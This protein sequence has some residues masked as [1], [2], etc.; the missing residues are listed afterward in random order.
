MNSTLQLLAYSEITLSHPHVLCP[1][2]TESGVLGFLLLQYDTMGKTQV[3]KERVYSAYTSPS[4][5]II[6]GSQALP[7]AVTF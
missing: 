7:N 5:F 6:K 1:A 2:L 4:Q 3:G